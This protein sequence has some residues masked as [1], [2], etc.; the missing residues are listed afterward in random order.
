MQAVILAAGRG[1][2]LRPLTDKIPK[3]LLKVAGKPILEHNLDQLPPQVEEVIIVVGY[4]KEKIKNY[5]GNEFNGR[6]IIYVECKKR[7]G[8]GHALMLCKD[9]LKD[10]KFIS[11]M[12]DDLYSK[13]DILKCIKYDLCV[14]AKEIKGPGR[15]GVVKVDKNDFIECITDDDFSSGT[16][17][18]LVN[19]GLFV[20]DKRIFDYEMIRLS[21]GEF[22]LPQTVGRMAK[23]YPIKVVKATSWLP[24]GYP[25]DLKKAEDYI[26]KKND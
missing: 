7:R 15:F 3:P 2:R 19:I 5:F 12:G 4:L 10:D 1:E 16:G 24:I 22:G 11:M 23:D 25:Q 26:L 21:S 6:K 20:L 8:T 9:F 14:L 17:S 18:V 13:K